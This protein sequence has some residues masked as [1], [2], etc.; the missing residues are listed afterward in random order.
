MTG[1]QSNYFKMVNAVVSLFESNPAAW[2]LIALL[3]KV[4][5]NL[6]AIRDAISSTA[7]KQE[8]NKPSGH[9]AAKEQARDIL[10]NL[11][12]RA[13]LRIRSYAAII[14][15]EVL[16]KTVRISHSTLDSMSIN[17]LVTYSRMICDVCSANLDALADYGID[18]TFVDELLG[19]TEQA[20]GLY[21]HR[22]VVI[23]QRMEATSRL[24][25]LFAQAR[26]QL[27]I[28]D[29]LVEGYVDDDVFVA[30]Y[31]NARRIH[32]LRGRKKS[33]K[34]ISGETES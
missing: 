31:F 24:Q 30:E 2:N 27:K 6:R 18:R 34:A 9:T 4:M 28:L 19:A 21:A 22:D 32:D 14:S 26:K 1:N 17:D 20:A 7:V 16:S 13:V 29:D 25:D 10:E 11:I 23:D 33:T 15:D 8:A 5:D 12:Y 3:V